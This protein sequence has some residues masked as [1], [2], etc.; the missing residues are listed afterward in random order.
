MVKRLRLV[1][2]IMSRVVS[3]LGCVRLFSVWANTPGTSDTSKKKTG[4]GAK[5]DFEDIDPRL[6]LHNHKT[7]V[8]WFLPERV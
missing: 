4:T 5:Q 2:L 7:T 8:I 1:A 6:K 3:V